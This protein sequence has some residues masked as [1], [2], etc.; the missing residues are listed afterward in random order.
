[1]DATKDVDGNTLLDN[2]LVIFWSEVS[3][4][5]AKGAVDMPV[6]LFGGKFLKMNGGSLLTLSNTTQT[7][8]EGVSRPDP[9]YMS[10]LWV[11]IAQ[12]W[13]YNLTAFGDL[14]WNTGPIQGIFG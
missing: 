3:N 4:G 11:T 12:A 8:A 2:T 5:N 1:M 10:D 6:V 14:S 13:G 9:P 7:P